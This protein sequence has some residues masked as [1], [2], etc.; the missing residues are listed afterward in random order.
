[1][2]ATMTAFAAAVLL[3]LASTALA[4]EP[5]GANT[6]VVR[7]K[8]TSAHA[9]APVRNLRRD[10]AQASQPFAAAEISRPE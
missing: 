8:D 3:G 7:D 2:K 10:V 1:M 9:R 4:T 6:P 5:F